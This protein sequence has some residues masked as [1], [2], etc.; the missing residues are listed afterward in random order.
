MPSRTPLLAAGAAALALLAA[1]C[2]GGG[3]RPSASEISEKFQSELDVSAEAGDCAGEVLA[4]SDISDDGLR[5]VIDADWG[6]ETDPLTEA[7]VSEED[8]A[9]GDAVQEE[10]SACIFGDLEVPTDTTEGG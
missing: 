6:A 3:D 9:A 8:N 5:K 2:G 1:A 4:D 7:D 10:L